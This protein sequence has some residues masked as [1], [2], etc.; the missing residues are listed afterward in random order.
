MVD[1]TDADQA[2]F[3]KYDKNK[4]GKLSKKEYLK[5]YTDLCTDCDGMSKKQISKRAKKAWKNKGNKNKQLKL[6]GFVT[7]V[8]NL[9]GDGS[10]Q[11]DA[12]AAYWAIDTNG[13]GKLRKKEF[14][15]WFTSEGKTL[16]GTPCAS[17]TE[18]QVQDAI[19]T[20][21]VDYDTNEDKWLSL[22]EFTAAY[23]YI[24]SLATPA[25]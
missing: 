4:N 7:I 20:Y 25:P 9:I 19:D 11:T 18:R 8:E 13:D 3:S 15:D 10:V 17:F 5:M 22:D 24:V 21:L 1:E 6:D 14:V 2:A 23:D 16:C 12:G